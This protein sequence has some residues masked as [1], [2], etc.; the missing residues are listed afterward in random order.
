MFFLGVESLS[1]T[2]IFQWNSHKTERTC[3]P[4]NTQT[5]CVRV[6]QHQ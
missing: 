2:I 5:Y 3:K 6:D 4:K 1:V